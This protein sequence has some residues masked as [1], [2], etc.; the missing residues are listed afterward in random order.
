MA[1][2]VVLVL[3]KFVNILTELPLEKYLLVFFRTILALVRGEANANGR[4][5]AIIGGVYKERVRVVW[6]I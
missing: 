4:I 2:V 5:I 6:E 1:A 3:G